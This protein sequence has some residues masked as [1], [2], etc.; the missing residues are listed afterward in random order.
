MGHHFSPVPPCDPTP[1]S[2][3]L[4]DGQSYPA[5]FAL[6]LILDMAMTAD[7]PSYLTAPGGNSKNDAMA[8]LE[9]A[10]CC[11]TAG[12]GDTA[13]QG[14]DAKWVSLLGWMGGKRDRDSRSAATSTLDQD[15]NKR[16]NSPQPTA[17]ATTT[18]VLQCPSSEDNGGLSTAPVSSCSSALVGDDEKVEAS[19][20]DDTGLIFFG[21][22]AADELDE[23]GGSE[24]LRR[25]RE[26][27]RVEALFTTACSAPINIP[28]KKSED[29][30]PIAM[31]VSAVRSGVALC[32]VS[33]L[34]VLCVRNVRS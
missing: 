24:G 14:A 26:Q 12:D 27:L 19:R 32:V 29:I 21:P 34:F 4:Y 3:H 17:A 9:N 28:V 18:M 15:Q 7:R 6:A 31:Q 20:E 23:E 11:S 1:P 10:A 16:R 22:K 8:S 30:N 33:S 13:G 5:A 2:V 25:C